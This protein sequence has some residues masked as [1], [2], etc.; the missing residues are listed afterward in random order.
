[1]K[2][3]PYPKARTILARLERGDDLLEGLTRACLRN[4]VRAG[5][6]QGIGAVERAVIGF[7]DQQAGKY[8]DIVLEGGREIASLTGNISLLD[9]Q[10]FVHAHVVLADAEGHCQGG[11]LMPGTRVFA[12]ELALQALQGQPPERSDDEATGLKLW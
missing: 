5:S 10:V 12:C 11:H 2:S 6:V 3:Y 1:M 8:R 9:G 4:G 7:Y